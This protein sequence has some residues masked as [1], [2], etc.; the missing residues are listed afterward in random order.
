MTALSAAA[1]L[2]RA[3]RHDGLHAWT[4]LAAVAT[5]ALA[6]FGSD[7]AIGTGA[8]VALDLTALAHWGVLSVTALRLGVRVPAPVWGATII[9]GPMSRGT[10]V[11]ARLGASMALIGAQATAL[12]VASWLGG[13]PA[14]EL[15][16]S[17]AR[18]WLE[19]TVW[20]SAA[21]LAATWVRPWVAGGA[22][23]LF[24]ALGHLQVEYARALATWELEGW[25]PV[26]WTLLPGL[27]L[28]QLAFSGDPSI[29]CLAAVHA[30]GWT[31]AL[32]LA[33]CASLYAQDLG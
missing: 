3:G 7:V 27:D 30:T 10:W 29:S 6:T 16:A 15:G 28:I 2:I 11:G 22:A 25:A 4:A 17:A 20:T 8:R 23:A 13:L 12:A 26:V 9:A 21:A 18:L 33:A 1:D 14:G 19:A 31:G 24:G 32:G 5:I